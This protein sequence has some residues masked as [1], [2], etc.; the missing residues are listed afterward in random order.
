MWK[1]P[2]LTKAF[3]AGAAIGAYRIVKFGTDDDTVILGTAGTDALIGITGQVGAAAAGDRVDVDMAGIGEVAA[4]DGI[5]RGNQLTSDADG[6][7][8]VAGAGDTVS[9]VAL[10]SAVSGDIIPIL[11]RAA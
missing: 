11:L 2:L 8:V 9:G 3:D 6:A 7:A 4:G 5:T 10:K 1:T